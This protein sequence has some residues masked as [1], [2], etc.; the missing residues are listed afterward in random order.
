M[1]ILYVVCGARPQHF[2][3]LLGTK[4]VFNGAW[5]NECVEHPGVYEASY[6]VAQVVEDFD[7]SCDV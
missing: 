2:V 3:L 7:I 5:H 6:I 1:L 4:P